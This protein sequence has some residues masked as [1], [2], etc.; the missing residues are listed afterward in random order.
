MSIDE[1]KALVRRYHEEFWRWNESVMDEMLTPD[2]NKSGAFSAEALKATLREVRRAFPDWTFKIDEMI[3]EGDK[4][5]LRWTMQGTHQGA[6]PGPF[7]PVQPTGKHVTLTGITINRLEGNKIADDRVEASDLSFYQQ[8][9]VI[10]TPAQDAERN[11]AVV[12]RYY[13]EI[14]NGDKWELVD[15]LLAPGF[16]GH[17]QSPGQE[18]NRA[19]IKEGLAY[20]R[21]S[22]SDYRQVV[23][24]MI[25]EG[26][27]V[28]AYYTFQGTHTGDYA[29]VPATGKR[30]CFP[31]IDI[32]QV[33]DGRLV[34][35]WFVGDTYGFMQQVGAVPAPAAN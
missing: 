15:E 12:R 27:R 25:A 28:V 14:V 33:R 16:Q 22:S 18:A 17:K 21:Q 34:G 23:E 9:G 24:E 10:P 1:Y 7:G 3:A 35:H 13:D 11:K 2:F 4:V 26:D 19:Q 30:F 29:G 31:G 5:M 20:L 6:Y 32:W 8:L